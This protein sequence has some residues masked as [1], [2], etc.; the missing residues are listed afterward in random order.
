MRFG[1][2][3][4]PDAIEA[5]ARAGFDFC[6]LPASAVLPFEDDA[7]ALPALRALDAGPLRPEAFNVLVPLTLPLAGP[8]RDLH[9]LRT[10]LRRAFGRM[11][12]LGGAVVVLGSGGARR[13]PDDMP[14]AEA[15]DQLAE[16]LALAADEAGRAGIALALEHL[17]QGETN[18]FNS[19]AE[20][21]A[22]IVERGLAGMQ[23]LADLYHLE[24]EHE[25]LNNVAAAAPLLAHVHVAGGG[26]RAPNIP[27]YDYAGFMSTL[28][29]IDYDLRISAECAWEDLAAQGPEALA[30]MR[31]QWS[32]EA[33][34]R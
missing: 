22:F 24:L 31:E 30:F 14:R 8:S 27:G 7:A 29:A 34:R 19:V 11:V 10:Y 18:V 13:I 17:N 3:G 32:G 9:A 33:M 15:L 28:H 21:H 12:Q 26:R 1:C 16:S 20:C 4:G 6:E 23:L 25:P 2:C 5:I